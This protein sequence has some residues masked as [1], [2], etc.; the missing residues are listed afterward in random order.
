MMM[1]VPVFEKDADEVLKKHDVELD[2]NDLGIAY[3]ALDFDRCNEAADRGETVS[4]K[5]RL[6]LECVAEQFMEMGYIQ[7]VNEMSAPAE[8]A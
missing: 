5:I 2:E 7:P 1:D 4:E 8:G 3:C 6:S